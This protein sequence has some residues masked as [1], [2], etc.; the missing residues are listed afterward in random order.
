[1]QIAA[2]VSDMF[3][4]ILKGLNA[5]LLF[6]LHTSLYNKHLLYKGNVIVLWAGGVFP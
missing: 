2:V 1:M 4:V 3:R 6:K 5:R